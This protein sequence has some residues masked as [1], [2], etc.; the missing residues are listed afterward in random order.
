[1]SSPRAAARDEREKYVDGLVEQAWWH[2]GR[3]L[4]YGEGVAYWALA[5]MVRM[6]ARI[7]EDEPTEEALGKLTAVVEE[8]VPDAEERAFVEP[9][10]GTCSGSPTA[11]RPTGRTSSPPGACSSS[12]WPSRT[13]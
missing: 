4:S 11:S 2:R 5:E 1:V 6:R 7:T 10:S 9:G 3:C 13:R 12:G 8:I